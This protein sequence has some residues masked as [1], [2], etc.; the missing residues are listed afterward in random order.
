M[1]GGC[2]TRTH[3]AIAIVVAAIA[4]TFPGRSMD[5]TAIA[6]RGDVAAVILD[7][8]D[9]MSSLDRAEQLERPA[10]LLLHTDS[11][12]D[13]RPNESRDPRSRP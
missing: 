12:H 2:Q 8:L 7:A 5:P 1:R 6:A 13:A 9:I 3:R 11:H 10:Q 4:K